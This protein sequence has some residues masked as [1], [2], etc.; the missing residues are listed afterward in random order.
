MEWI[1]DRDG[2]P[3]YLFQ[4][5]LNVFGKKTKHLKTAG[6]SV[7]GLRLQ[8]LG[9]LRALWRANVSAS[10]SRR[11]KGRVIRQPRR[12]SAR[13]GHR[14]KRLGL[15]MAPCAVTEQL[16]VKDDEGRKKK[17]NLTR[18]FCFLSRTAKAYNATQISG[19]IWT[20]GW[21]KQRKQWCAGDS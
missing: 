3:R 2:F 15:K 14:E 5:V 1:T 12:S 8:S 9:L 19:G 10:C 21:Y 13:W 18:G 11:E 16:T 7:C 6:E 17:K 4:N 20:T